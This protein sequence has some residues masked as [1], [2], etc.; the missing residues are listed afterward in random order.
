MPQPDPLSWTLLFKKHRTTVLLMLPAS[1]TVA[2]TKN[3]LLRAL[4]ARGLRDINGDVVPVDA[5]EIELGIPVDK[6]DLE[7]GWTKLEVDVADFDVAAAPK[8]GAGK[9]AAGSLTLLAADIKNGQ[10]IAFRF[11]KPTTD[12]SEKNDELAELD[13]EDPGWDVVLPSFEDEEDDVQN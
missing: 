4:Q 1:E 10:S 8:R 6:N 3:A 11:R 13:P 2:A 9:K 7:K 12:D 5:S